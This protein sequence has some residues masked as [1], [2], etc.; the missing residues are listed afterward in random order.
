M[1]TIPDAS[2]S[3]LKRDAE[4]DYHDNAFIAGVQRSMKEAH[5]RCAE[6]ERRLREEAERQRDNLLARIHRDGGHYVAKHGVKEAVAD[7]DTIVAELLS[8][9]DDRE[10]LE[11]RLADAERLLAKYKEDQDRQDTYDALDWNSD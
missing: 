9:H 7:A 3:D 8:K 10:A 5:I 2:E 4:H 6:H 1:S 11:K